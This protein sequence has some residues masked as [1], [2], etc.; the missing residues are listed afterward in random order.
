[1][2]RERVK[3]GWMLLVAVA[4]MPL[5]GCRTTHGVSGEIGEV[6]TAAGDNGRVFL[7]VDFE[8]GQ[9]LRYRFVSRRQITLD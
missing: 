8:P 5:A 4:M 1:M 2:E 9:T 6:K 7:T 3:T